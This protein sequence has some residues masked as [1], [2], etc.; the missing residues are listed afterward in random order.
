MINLQKNQARAAQ[1]MQLFR[2][3]TL[4]CPSAALACKSGD[5]SLD[6]PRA[7]LIRVA[8]KFTRAAKPAVVIHEGVLLLGGIEIA[9][10]NMINSINILRRSNHENL[11]PTYR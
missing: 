5:L 8:E 7:I 10:S 9:H 6:D 3:R 1:E 11:D 4:L 2:S